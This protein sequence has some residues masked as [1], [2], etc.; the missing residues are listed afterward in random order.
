MKDASQVLRSVCMHPHVLASIQ[1][2]IASTPQVQWPLVFQGIEDPEDIKALIP[3][4][5]HE[6]KNE[7]FH[8]AW[9]SVAQFQLDPQV[10][11]RNINVI[12]DLATK[13]E[14]V[15]PVIVQKTGAQPQELREFA[16]ALKKVQALSR[17]TTRTG[18]GT[19]QETEQATSAYAGI[20]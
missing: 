13:P 20:R 14:E 1:E 17:S 7:G 15:I 16:E 2:V 4:L 9:L 10:Q 11:E 19:Y 3:N 5:V 18:T 6:A 8:R 12:K